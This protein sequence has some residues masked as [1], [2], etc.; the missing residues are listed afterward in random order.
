MASDTRRSQPLRIPS[1]KRER[2]STVCRSIMVSKLA[3]YLTR[4]KLIAG[5]QVLHRTVSSNCSQS[6]SCS[7]LLNRG[8]EVLCK[9]GVP[10]FYDV[11]RELRLASIHS[12]NVNGDKESRKYSDKRQDGLLP[13][14]NSLDLSNPANIAFQ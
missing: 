5:T 9:D 4:F 3:I 12:F 1:L 14:C 10:L 7:R 6:Q 8:N 13:V 2:I 11:I